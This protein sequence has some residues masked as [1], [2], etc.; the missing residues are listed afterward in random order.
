MLSQIRPAI[1]MIVFFTVLTGLIY[2]LGMTGI[3]QALFPRQANGSL[4]EKDGKVI[5]SGLIGQGFASDKYF[6]GRPSA[7][8]S[9]GYDATASG[10]SNLG[11]TNPKLIDRIKGDAEKLK[12]ENP[13]QPVPMDL[14]TT[15][16]S[17]LD[18]AISPEAAYFQVARVAKARGLDEAK[19]K[20][21]VDSHIDGR[22]LGFLGEPVVNVLALNLALD[23][24]K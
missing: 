3:A 17:G 11:P 13:N 16:G 18:P 2:P 9:S 23:D 7:A 20:A 21:L 24:A 6:H 5:G 19:V 14:V 22:E 15:S 10:G 1:V 12:A 8:G 4:V